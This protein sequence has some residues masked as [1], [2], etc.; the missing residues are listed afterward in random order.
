MPT[1]SDIEP[2]VRAVLRALAANK[3]VLISGPPGTGKSRLLAK[4]RE[5]FEWQLGDTG[6]SPYGVI[7]LPPATSPIPAWFPSPDRATSRASYPTVFDQNTKYRDFMRGL[8]PTVGEAAQFEVTNGTLYR[9]SLDAKQS[10]HAALVIIDEINRGPAVAAFGSAIVGLEP[11]KRLDSDGL[12]TAD[13]QEFEILGDQGQHELFALPN[14]LYILAAMNEADSSVEPLDVAFLR[15]FYGYRLEPDSN[16]LRRH[17]GLGETVAELPESPGEPSDIYAA[18][19][20]A[21]EVINDQILLGRGAPYRLGQGALMPNPAPLDSFGEAREYVSH[22]WAKIRAHV[23]EVFFGNTRALA[24]VL[25]ADDVGS[26]YS[27]VETTFAG[28]SVRRI[29]GPERPSDEQLYRLLKLI[30]S[31]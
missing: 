31:Q 5:Y 27:Q 18:L 8:V 9:A 7:P 4:V 14:D 28:Q 20:R 25:R 29:I 11:D 12:R 16:V 2:D 6:A 15:R 24:D 10:G 22:G 3:N 30:A 21:W 17:F 26:P 1:E 19:V 23:D 13:T